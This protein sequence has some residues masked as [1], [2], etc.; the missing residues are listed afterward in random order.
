M[1]VKKIIHM[2]CPWTLTTLRK[3]LLDYRGAYWFTVAVKEVWSLF[4]LEEEQSLFSN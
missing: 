3:V 4:T 1:L 2:T